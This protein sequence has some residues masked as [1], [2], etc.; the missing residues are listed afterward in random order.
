LNE[1]S[2]Q[3]MYFPDA[4]SENNWMKLRDL[5]VR[6]KVDPES[7]AGAIR[8]AVW[9]VDRDQPVSDVMSLD[10]LLDKEVTRWR[11]EATLLGAL[12]LLALTLACVGT[13][14]VLSYLDA[15]RTQEIG[16]R[17]AL[18][19][20]AW[21]VFNS[22]TGHGM[23]LVAIGIAAGLMAALG[24]SRLLASLLFD[25]NPQDLAIYAGTAAVFGIIAFAACAIPANRAAR[26]DPV[27]AL[28]YE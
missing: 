19:A 14:G 6:T 2:R 27:I 5:V 16:I 28:R 8:Q 13:Y 22:V 3:E 25:V 26:V 18:G 12:A 20:D 10:D 9:S 11:I 7:I 4:R 23:T 15:Q 21:N 17:L 24:V 1:P